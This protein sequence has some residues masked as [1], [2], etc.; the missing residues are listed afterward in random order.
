MVLA[1][2][3]NVCTP[4]PEARRAAPVGYLEGQGADA[5]DVGSCSTAFEVEGIRDF[6]LLLSKAALRRREIQ[7]QAAANVF[8]RPRFVRGSRLLP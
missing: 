4:M 2:V 3:T 6:A 5:L 1:P 7:T 8:S